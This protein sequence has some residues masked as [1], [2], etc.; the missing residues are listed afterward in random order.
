MFQAGA[1]LLAKSA[2]QK[3]NFLNSQPKHMLKLMGK[4]IFTFYAQICLSKPMEV[5]AFEAIN[6]LVTN[7]V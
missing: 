7:H 5:F 4:K 3:Y 1:R 6:V 2:Y